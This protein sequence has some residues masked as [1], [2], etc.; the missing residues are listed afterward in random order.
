[1]TTNRAF[2]SH[3]DLEGILAAADIFETFASFLLQKSEELRSENVNPENLSLI[4]SNLRSE[5]KPFNGS[6]EDLG[7]IAKLNSVIEPPLTFNSNV[8]QFRPRNTNDF[9]DIPS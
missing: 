9:P 6:V 3:D 5:F 7:I 1:M 2:F 8:L 4:L